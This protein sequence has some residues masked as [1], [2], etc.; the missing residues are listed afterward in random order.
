MSDASTYNLNCQKCQVQYTLD[1]VAFDKSCQNKHTFLFICPECGDY[2]ATAM[3]NIPQEKWQEFV[4]ADELDD[5]L[6]KHADAMK[7]H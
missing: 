1:D 3:A 2:K 7:S 4:P 5:L 6:Q